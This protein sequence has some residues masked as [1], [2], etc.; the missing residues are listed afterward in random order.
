MNL[1]K[2][3]YKHTTAQAL[4]VVDKC[5]RYFTQGE[6]QKIA[7]LKQ[8][9]A[10]LEYYYKIKDTD[11]GARPLYDYFLSQVKQ[12]LEE[13]NKKYEKCE[14]GNRQVAFAFLSAA[15]TICLAKIK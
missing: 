11:K 4:Q 10:A 7:I 15:I 5:A 3:A 6:N 1:D 8:Q 2:M 9:I 12:Q 14:P 13:V